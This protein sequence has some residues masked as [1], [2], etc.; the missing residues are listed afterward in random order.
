M[1]M[2]PRQPLQKAVVWND[3]P[4][5][6]AIAQ[7]ICR[8]ISQGSGLLPSAAYARAPKDPSCDL[9]PCWQF[10]AACDPSAWGLWLPVI[11]LCC[12]GCK[13]FAVLGGGARDSGCGT[14]V[15]GVGCKWFAVLGGGRDCG[16]G[17]LVL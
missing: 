6:G 12:L 14:L 3:E 11:L 7:G 10:R 1:N 5:V 15:L 13:G 17:S 8:Q 4:G 16:F 9:D 2:Q